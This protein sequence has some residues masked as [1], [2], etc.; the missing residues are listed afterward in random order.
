MSSLD[1]MLRRRVPYSELPADSPAASARR[2]AC[3][4]ANGR[5]IDPI[6]Y[7]IVC[8]NPTT[9]SVVVTSD[10]AVMLEQLKIHG[11]SQA[12]FQRNHGPYLSRRHE[13][14]TKLLG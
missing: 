9:Q 3:D 7:T 8:G 13:E 6:D 1:L 2:M 12:E 5:S 11:A 14:Y 4:R 10:P